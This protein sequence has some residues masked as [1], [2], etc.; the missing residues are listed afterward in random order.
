MITTDEELLAGL[1]QIL[2]ADAELMVQHRFYRGARAPYHFVCRTIEQLQDYLKKYAKPGDDVRF[3][4]LAD[5]CR[6][7]NVLRTATVPDAQG[8]TPQ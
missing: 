7:A 2:E 1:R 4:R 5:S 3:W 6:D 8:R